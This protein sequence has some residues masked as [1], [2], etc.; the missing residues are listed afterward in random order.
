[1]KI[2][3][4]LLILAL[5]IGLLINKYL[6][7]KIVDQKSIKTENLNTK[8]NKDY[9]ITKEDYEKVFKQYGLVNKWTFFEKHL[10]PEI[11][12]KLT[13]FDE[14]NMIIGQSKI[15]GHPDLPKN[16]DWPKE[17]NGKYFLFLAQ[18]NFKEL[19]N[20]EIDEIPKSGIIYFFYSEDYTSSK[21]IFIK[22][23]SSL[24]RKEAPNTISLSRSSAYNSNLNSGVFN[25][26][27]IE[28]INTYSLPNSQY[29][30]VSKQL[31]EQEE[32]K[33][34]EIPK[35]SGYITK[36]FGHPNIIQSPMEYECELINRGY[37][38]WAERSTLDEKEKQEISNN[39]HDWKLLFQIDSEKE[40]KMMWGDVGR[41][42]FW[43]KEKDLKEQN[44]DNVI[45]IVQCC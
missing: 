25:S 33:Y 41:L 7:K 40:T 45:A 12:I 43:I 24:E 5:L 34:Q 21:T 6:K 42:Y 29:K 19:D 31:K 13:E 17:K 1:M 14:N 15:G 10:K 44:F 16:T 8:E 35:Y 27:N 2:I 18:I 3:G 32:Y 28:F 4:I 22:D 9:P 30:Y 26:C 38:N 37:N 36:L 23:L 39:Q 20:N 11:W